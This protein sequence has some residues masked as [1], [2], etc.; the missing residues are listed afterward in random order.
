MNVCVGGTV[1]YTMHYK[2][3]GINDL[4]RGK[5]LIHSYPVDTAVLACGMEEHYD[6]CLVR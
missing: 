3:T 4:A 5:D 2:R 1:T 6:L